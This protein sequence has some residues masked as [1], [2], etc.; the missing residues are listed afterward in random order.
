MCYDSSSSA[1]GEPG[2]CKTITEIALCCP[3]DRC[4]EWWSGHKYRCAN[5]WL[6]L[7]LRPFKA[8]RG[9]EN[10]ACACAT[11]SRIIEIYKSEWIYKPVRSF[12]HLQ[13]IIPSLKALQLLNPVCLKM[14][15]AQLFPKTVVVNIPQSEK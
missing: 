2:W 7:F 13:F 11:S 9:R 6:K 14:F 1:V 5:R 15:F 4:N 3:S 8:N 12:M 10:E